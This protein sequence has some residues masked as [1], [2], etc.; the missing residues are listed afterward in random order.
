MTQ[1]QQKVL[2]EQLRFHCLP[3]PT[4][5]ARFHSRRKW[6]CDALWEESKL[7]MECEGGYALQGR[8]TRAS[9]FLKDM[10]KYNTLA[11]L[12]Y[13]LIRVTPRQLQDWTAVEWVRLAL[14]D[15]LRS[16]EKF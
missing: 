4:F 14:L 2:V 10:E 15:H 1:G 12:G 8:H 6:R 3:L 5:E 7:A 13:R 16:D 9:G 11:V